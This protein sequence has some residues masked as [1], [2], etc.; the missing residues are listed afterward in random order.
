MQTS[1]NPTNP[2]QIRE[3]PRIHLKRTRNN[4]PLTERGDYELPRVRKNPTIE[5]ET[6]PTKTQRVAQQQ[7][8]RVP[9]E[10]GTQL[11]QQHMKQIQTNE[12][13]GPDNNVITQSQTQQKYNIPPRRSPRLQ[14]DNHYPQNIALNA[15][16][17]HS[18]PN[19]ETF[20]CPVI[21]PV[22]GKNITKYKRIS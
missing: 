15:V 22:T 6:V 8:A 20:R 13:K 10:Q 7:F 12:N 9:L 4:I 1:T 5:S 21:H 14:L 16:H 17:T 18:G 19:I 2:K 11:I 3:E